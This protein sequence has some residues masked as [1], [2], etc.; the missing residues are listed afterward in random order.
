MILVTGASG[1]LGSKLVSRAIET[2]KQVTALSHRHTLRFAGADAYNLDLR[3]FAATR[4]LVE[5]LRPSAIAHCAAATN[6]D[7][8]EDNPEEAD[9]LNVQVPVFWARLA[10]ERGAHFL[11]VSTDSVFNGY[12][13]NYSESDAPAPLNVYAKTKW[14]AEQEVLKV[15]PSSLIARV[16]F[17]GWNVQKKQSLAEWILDG[18]SAGKKMPGFT[19]V[20]FCPILANDLAEI[21]LAMIDRGLHGTYNAV[22]S[23]K[24]SKFDFAKRLAIEFG[25]D[26]DQI[27]SVSIADANL[28]AT[29]PGDTSLTTEKIVRQLGRAMPDVQAGL[30]RF[31]ELREA[32]C[33]GT[34][35]SCPSGAER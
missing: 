26:A 34:A 13:G 22:G 9:R 35:Q 32:E 18:L 24:I 12:S 29:R 14:L 15:H 10:A 6:V 5:N 31:R 11:Q 4:R 27:I 20:Y 30:R 21:L 16:T 8:C 3:D 2:S 25:F 19:D 17:Y 28:R 1:L 33:I 7:W 23:E